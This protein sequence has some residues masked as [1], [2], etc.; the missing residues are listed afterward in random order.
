MR[1]LD[2]R[3]DVPVS[4]AVACAIA[5]LARFTQRPSAQQPRGATIEGV[6][7]ERESNAPIGRASVELRRI[8]TGPQQPGNLGNVDGLVVLLDR[9]AGG[10]TAGGTAS[11]A[12]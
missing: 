12:P 3:I 2:E 9:G 1:R 5:C 6:V 8:Q 10:P 7:V 4:A 11:V